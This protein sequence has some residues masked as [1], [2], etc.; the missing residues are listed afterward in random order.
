MARYRATDCDPSVTTNEKPTET[1]TASAVM[2]IRPAAFG[3]NDATRP[4]NRFQVGNSGVP[5]TAA[6]ALTEFDNLVAKLEQQGIDVR[7]FPGRAT[8]MLPDEVFPNNWVSTHADGTAV[9]YPL[10]AWNRRPER[11]V[12]V[13]DALQQHNDGYR[14]DR[15]INL[16]AL[17]KVDAFLEGTGSLVLDRVNRI[18]YACLSPRTHARGLSEFS[19]RLDYDVVAFEASDRNGYPIFHTNVMMSLGERFAVVC[20]DA[21]PDVQTRYRVLR[22][23]ETGNRAVIELSVAQLH[24]FAGNLLELKGSTG[25]VITLSQ[26]AFESLD[27]AQQDALSGYG[28]ITAPAIDTIET[29]GGGS[30]R[31][32]LTEI[33]LPKKTAR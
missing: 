32:M 10:M 13:L 17:E 19:K 1:Q 7:A 25:S 22:R 9:L 33:F 6:A 20:L 4:S 29:Y 18:A 14:I 15:I 31:C 27:A 26:R 8:T 11:R 23:L 28:T 2:M 24:S 16:A 3:P 12:D 5:E 30:V 21:I